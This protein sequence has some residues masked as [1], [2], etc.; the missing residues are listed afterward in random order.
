MSFFRIFLSA[1]NMKSGSVRKLSHSEAEYQV[2][3]VP[4]SGNK[5]QSSLTV[6]AKDKRN[7]NPAQ[8]RALEV[9]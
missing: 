4:F 7:A 9:H 5:A 8:R 3:K 6:R 2:G 1:A